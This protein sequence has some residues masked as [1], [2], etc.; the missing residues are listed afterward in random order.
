[1]R[2]FPF[3]LLSHLFCTTATAQNIIKKDSTMLPYGDLAA[4]DSIGAKPAFVQAYLDKINT[5]LA[6]KPAVLSFETK[7]LLLQKAQKIA[8]QDARFQQYLTDAQSQKAMR[9]EVF[10]VF[11]ARKS[12]IRPEFAALFQKG[13]CYRVEMYNFAL[14][15]TTLGLVSLS[16]NRVFDAATLQHTAPDIP[17]SL[18]ELAL[19]IAIESPEVIAALGFKPT[20]EQ[21]LMADTKTALNRTRCERSRHLCVAPTFIKGEKALW[22]IVDL[23]DLRLVGVRW[24]NTS[25][26]N[27]INKNTQNTQNGT[28]TVTQRGLEYEHLTECFCKQELVH[29]QGDWDFK[30]MITSSDGLRISEVKYKEKTVVSSAKLVD[31]HVSYSK[32]DGFGYSDAIGCPFFST[33][34]VLALEPPRFNDLLEDGKKVGFVLEQGFHSEGWPAPCNY[35]Y[36]QRYEFYTDGRLRCA[37][38][39]VGRGCGNDGTYRP[40]FRI[41]FPQNDNSFAEWNGKEWANWAQEKWQLQTELTAYNDKRFQYKITDKAQNGFLIEPSQ[42]KFADKGRGDN[43][44]VFITKQHADMDEG[45]ADLITIGPCCNTDYHQGPEKFIEP[46]PEN[47]ANETLVLWY[48]PQLKND[49]TKGSEYCWAESYLKNGTLAVRTFPCFGGPMLVPVL[50]GK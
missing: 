43:A 18:K 12:D 49:N 27:D 23:T 11:A 38:A 47:I 41:A 26:N 16:E 1:M 32:T 13:D 4:W 8:L 46:K 21:A 20:A 35:N 14:N 36:V 48:V 19:K 25:G 6:Q 9:N 50:N 28:K 45:E 7:D 37:T 22:A 33:A 24:T 2:L 29:Q 15:L 39:S 30:Y 34:T 44:F 17:A 42:G 31:W 10:G 3:L 40:V 5:T